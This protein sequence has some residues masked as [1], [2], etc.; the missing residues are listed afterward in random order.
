[1]RVVIISLAA[2]VAFLPRPAC[3]ADPFEIEVYDGTANEPGIPSLELHANSVPSGR[4]ESVVPELPPNHQS[5]F[6]VEAALGL[7]PWWEIGGYLQSTLLGNGTFEYAGAKLRSKF[8]TPPSFCDRVRFGW[9]ARPLRQ[10][11][12]RAD[13]AGLRVQWSSDA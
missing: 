13:A 1:L 6:T 10:V 3:A 5:H 11:L 7:L 4:R 2:L 8:V 9:H 12:S